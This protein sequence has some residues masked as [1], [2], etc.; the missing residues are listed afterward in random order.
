MF[1]RIGLFLVLNFVVLITISVLVR[2]LGVDRWLTANGIDYAQ[3]MAFSA[4]CG[5]T[6]SFISLM[7]SKSIAKMTTG[8]SV[9]SSPRNETEAW[10]LS[11]VRDLSDRAGLKM[12]EVAIYEGTPN[13]FA[14]GAFK[15]D[16][17]VAVSTGLM[18]GMTRPQIRA[19]LAHEV[20]HIRNGDMV[21]MTL[22]QGVL[23]TFVFFF[24]RV[25]ALFLQNRGSS[26]G[27][28]R[29]GGFSYYVV[30][31]V[32]EILFGI[33]ASIVSCAFSRRREYRADAG[34]AELTGRPEDM[35]D[36]LRALGRMESEPLPSEMKAF[37][38][39]DLP[40]FSELF[41]TH[42]PLSSR[43]EALSGLSSGKT[44]P[45]V[46]RGE[47]RRSTGGLFGEVNSDDHSPW[48]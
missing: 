48:S 2:L 30:V 31:P 17:L 20:S 1:K 23:N 42:P 41:S 35:I 14:T 27:E 11:T 38:I 29:I 34:A 24:A 15:D 5:F 28:R 13:A 44:E 10:L 43:I 7:M 39:T 4:V 25:A 40:S 16:A 8:A 45:S 9:I 12:P 37:G 46:E 3:L 32:F 22:L 36:A 18:Q 21:T 47:R 33:L 19:V 26:D 6:G